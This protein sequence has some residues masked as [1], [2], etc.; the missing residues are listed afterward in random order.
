MLFHLE[1]FFLSNKCSMHPV[2][3]LLSG[4]GFEHVQMLSFTILVACPIVNSN[5]NA[6]GFL[7]FKT[8]SKCHL[9]PHQ[10]LS[11]FQQTDRLNHQ[12]FC[13]CFV[14]KYFNSSKLNLN[15]GF[16]TTGPQAGIQS[17]FMHSEDCMILNSNEEGNISKW[18][19]YIIGIANSA[20][21]KH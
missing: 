12:A 2:I 16:W 7:Y 17:G 21:A 5:R 9:H 10:I 1:Y 8:V 18:V 3:H 4:T 20:F 14:F 13:F 6:F 15:R 19:K 11:A